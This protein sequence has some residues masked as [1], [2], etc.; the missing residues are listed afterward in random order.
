MKILF[1]SIV[2]FVL[3]IYANA[4]QVAEKE[5][6][7]Y[8]EWHLK[9]K[10]TSGFFGISIDKAYDLL[11]GRKSETVIVAVIDS[12]IDTLQEDLKDILWINPKEKPG[13]G[14]DDDGNGYIDD[15]YGWNFCGSKDGNNLKQNS[16]EAVRVYHQWKDEFAGKKEKHIS[17]D[18]LFLFQQWKKAKEIIEEKYN[19]A[20][21]NIDDITYAVNRFDEAAKLLKSVYKVESFNFKELNAIDIS[22]ATPRVQEAVNNWKRILT[23]DASATDATVLDDEKKYLEK[24]QTDIN[25]YN[26][27]P[28]DVRMTFTHD[29]YTDISDKSYGNNNLKSESGD[30]G[31]LTA[32]TIAALRDN[33]IG[34][35]GIVNDVR[36]MALRA[37]PGG[38]EHDK[39]I[40]L[41]IRYAVDNGAQIIN[42]SFGKPVSPYKQFVD[43]AVAYA[44]SKNVLL[45]HS[46]GNDA[47]NI[48]EYVFYPSATYLNGKKATNFIS[49]GANDKD[50]ADG[51]LPASFSNY[52]KQDVDIFAPGVSIYSTASN[53]AYKSVDG[54]SFSGPVV[55]GVAAL[56]KSYFPKLTPQQIIE[57]IIKSGTIVN[58]DVRIPGNDK[59]K[60]VPFSDI[61]ASGKII[62][63][64]EAVKLALQWETEKKF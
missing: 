20:K 6:K 53:N 28:E 61:C 5:N 11:K 59:V 33:G 55:S 42:M 58:E 15:H 39:D 49:V 17:A 7:D 62:N 12:G 4:Q 34:S 24:L 31:T 26:V 52:S 16:T 18:K 3:S 50:N 14:I 1:L 40:A 2:C 44:E 30:H 51:T 27:M 38:D 23:R 54:T 19:Y 22:S 13:N 56:L 41:A 9:D 47:K 32:G 64:Y 45:V 60:R 25:N 8:K 46:A 43:D 29:N 37:V 35:K 10:E 36:I 57:I 21:K 48:S 63:A